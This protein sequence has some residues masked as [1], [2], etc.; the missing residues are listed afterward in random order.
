[1][2]RTWN[3]SSVSRRRYLA[4]GL[5]GALLLGLIVS[6]VG[7]HPALAAT[8]TPAKPTSGGEFTFVQSATSANTSGDTTFINNSYINSNPYAVLLV[9]PVWNPNNNYTGFDYTR[10]GVWYDSWAQQWGIFNEDGSAMTMGAQFDVLAWNTAG[11]P[12]PT[13][14]TGIYTVTASSTSSSYSMFI[15][16]PLSNGNPNVH[17][18]ITPDWNLGGSWSGVY[19]NHPASVWYNSWAGMWEIYHD[20]LTNIPPDATYNVYIDTSTWYPVTVTRNTGPYA[21]I[22]AS[23]ING[24][25]AATPIITHDW[26]GNYVT[27]VLGVWY[28]ASIGEWCIFDATGGSLPASEQFFVE[29]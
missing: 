25:P 15:N 17:I 21:C 23:T 29:P 6:F 26:S 5:A 20:D 24:N 27:D 11:P 19:D 13:D 28:Y 1:M 4:L 7:V 9:T 12:Q 18:F 8:R 14:G 22:N 3:W 10:V 2:N 16:Y